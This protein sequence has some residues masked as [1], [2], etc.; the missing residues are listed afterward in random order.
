MEYV[1][2]SQEGNDGS[3]NF[4]VLITLIFCLSNR[5]YHYQIKVIKKDLK[6]GGFNFSYDGTLDWKKE[7]FVNK[8]KEKYTAESLKEGS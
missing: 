7:S 5:H 3:P 8:S 4:L 6:N 2:S 1:S